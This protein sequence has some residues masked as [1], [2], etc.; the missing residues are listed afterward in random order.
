MIEIIPGRYR[1]AATGAA[2]VL[3]LG[4]A[5]AGGAIVNG[6]RL[7]AMHRRELAGERDARGAL[8]RRLLEQDAAVALLG[9]QRR[10][11]DERRQLAERLAA[12]A[13]DSAASRAK[14][15]AA[16]RAPD[17]DGVMREAWGS[18]K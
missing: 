11:A 12:A 6:W 17:C 8:E 2:L 10:A 7:E 18:W 13:I 15:V 14:A 16:S 9:A 3:A 1:L 4:A 5:A